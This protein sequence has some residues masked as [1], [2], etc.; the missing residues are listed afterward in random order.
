MLILPK[1]KL[2][3]GTNLGMLLVLYHPLR[4]YVLVRFLV[5]DWALS[6]ET[7]GTPNRREG[8]GEMHV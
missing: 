4:G 5:S 3:T 1:Q 8:Q 6:P 2:V 7:V